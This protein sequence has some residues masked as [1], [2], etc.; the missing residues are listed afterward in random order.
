MANKELISV[1]IPVYNVAPFLRQCLDSVIKQ[2]YT[3]LQILIIDD[4]SND[5]SEKICDEY[6]S[7]D[8]RI[9]VYH[10]AKAGLCSV[11]NFGLSLAV[12]EYVAFVDSDDML[13][14]K[15]YECMY[16]TLTSAHADLVACKWS[17]KEE[18]VTN[19]DLRSLQITQ[20]NPV[21]DFTKFI[22]ETRVY[23]W[24]K[25]FKRTLFTDFKY[26]EG[27][28]AESYYIHRFAYFCPN[29]LVIQNPLYYYRMREGSYIHTFKQHI[30]QRIDGYFRALDDRL[31][32]IAEHE[33]KENLSATVSLFCERA[34]FLARHCDK[35][36]DA[37]FTYRNRCREKVKDLVKTYPQVK[38]PFKF[39]LWAKHPF[40]YKVLHFMLRC[41]RKIKGKISARKI[42][43]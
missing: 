28:V 11:L 4:A 23:R 37:D 42:A 19:A 41:V 3:N 1:I 7:L 29:T 10:R 35:T 2:S 32:F 8:K 39:K 16:D 9:S 36:N 30:G 43:H 26:P 31:A 27:F 25:L 12:G 38:L 33:W 6:T 17:K 20:I 24:N 22:S 14:P 5:G 40:V 15:M 34:I 21:T 13:H 18:E